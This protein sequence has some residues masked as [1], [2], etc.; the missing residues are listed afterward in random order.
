M[1]PKLI[2]AGNPG[3]YTGPTG[4]NTWLVDGAAPLLVD[5]GVGHDAHVG[6]LKQVLGGRALAT[7]FITHAH[8][9]HSAGAPRLR[10]VFPSARVI[11]G[12]HG[13]PVEPDGWVPAGDRRMQIIATPGHASDHACLWDPDER[14]MFTGDL[15]VAG[16]TVMIAGAS[17]GNL[18]AYLDSLARVRGLSPVRG[19]PGHGPVIDDPIALVDQYVAHRMDRERQ[20][21][22]ALARG[23][24]T[25]AALVPVI[26]PDLAPPLANAA[27][28]TLLA[29]LGKLEEEGRVT[30]RDGIWSI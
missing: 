17:G 21:L 16:G 18:R 11:G 7:V 1:T 3:P 10:E 24:S 13:E 19:Y 30:R 9:D 12:P 26:Y 25:A 4:N 27:E 29:H 28:Q 2:P 14:A 8:K 23:S 6:E 22:S 5:A 20:V 15:L